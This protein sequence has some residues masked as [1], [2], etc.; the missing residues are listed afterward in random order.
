MAE[1]GIS[2]PGAAD[3]GSSDAALPAPPE[4]ENLRFVLPALT[5]LLI[6][7]ELVS[8]VGL[9]GGEDILAA[10]APLIPWKPKLRRWLR[11]RLLRS[12]PLQ[13]MHKGVYIHDSALRL[14]A[15]LDSAEYAERYMRGAWRSSD[16]TE[17]LLFGLDHVRCQGLYLEF[18][19]WRGRT[20]NLIA[21]RVF[22]ETVHGFDSFEGLPEEWQR[23]YGK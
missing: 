16:M 19:V 7:V 20:I 14:A 2:P 21:K 11:D 6:I 18:G 17:V 1:R 23:N 15:M 8:S 4:S 5:F 22:Y 13:I 12:R 9:A 3:M 10:N